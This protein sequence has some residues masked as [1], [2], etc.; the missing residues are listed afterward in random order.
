MR[1]FYRNRRDLV[2]K[3]LPTPFLSSRGDD[4][5]GLLVAAHQDFGEFI[6]GVRRELAQE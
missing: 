1:I 3:R 5:R 6:A 2:K 4:G